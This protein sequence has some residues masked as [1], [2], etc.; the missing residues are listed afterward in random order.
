MNALLGRWIG[1]FSAVFL[2]GVSVPVWYNPFVTAE[3]VLTTWLR[4]IEQKTERRR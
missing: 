2:V 4:R 1:S 3:E